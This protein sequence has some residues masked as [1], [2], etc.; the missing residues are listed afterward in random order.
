VSE[1][2]LPNRGLAEVLD[3]CWCC[4]PVGETCVPG[5]RSGLGRALLAQ[6]FK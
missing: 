4:A 2:V 1:S 5:N 3:A 6:C